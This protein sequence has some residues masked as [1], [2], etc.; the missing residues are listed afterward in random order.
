M[1]VELGTF[2]A[3][4]PPFTFPLLKKA[5]QLS[6]CLSVSITDFPGK[7]DWLC[8]GQVVVLL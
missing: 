6:G 8:P 2:Q 3:T 4:A 1:P 5:V 7:L